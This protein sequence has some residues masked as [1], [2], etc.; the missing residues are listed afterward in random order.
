MQ[1][2][3]SKRRS[4]VDG[5]EHVQFALFRP[6]L[7]DIDTEIADRIGFELLAN[8]LVAADIGKLGNAMAL[9]ATMQS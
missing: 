3:E 5:N 8:R 4:S 9:Q 7:G 6:H 2:H 1:L